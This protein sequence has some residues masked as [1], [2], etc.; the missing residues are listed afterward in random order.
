MKMPEWKPGFDYAV[1]RACGH[2]ETVTV[3]GRQAERLRQLD[4]S[5]KVMCNN[6]AHGQRGE[7]DDQNITIDVSAGRA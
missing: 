2:T 1:C 7:E 5:R 3:Y 6:C 4:S